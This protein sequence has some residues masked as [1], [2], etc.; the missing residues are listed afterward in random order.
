[1]RGRRRKEESI[2]AGKE[3]AARCFA[4]AIRNATEIAAINA[5]YIL[6]IACAAIACALQREPLPV[7]TEIRFGILSSERDLAQ[8]TEMPLIWLCL[9]GA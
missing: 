4:A 8:C 1:V 5:H 9:N 7:V 6:L 3:P 2:V